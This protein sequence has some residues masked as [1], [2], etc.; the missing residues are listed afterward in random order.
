MKILYQF[1][2]SPFG[3]N[4]PYK[5]LSDPPS[6]P[7]SIRPKSG[8]IRKT[9]VFVTPPPLPPFPNLP[10]QTPNLLARL[11]LVS[12]KRCPMAH[13]LPVRMCLISSSIL[14]VKPWGISLI[15]WNERTFIIINSFQYDS[16]GRL[17]IYWQRALKNNEFY[18]RT[19]DFILV[20]FPEMQLS[21]S[22]LNSVKSVIFL[23]S[24]LFLHMQCEIHLNAYINLKISKYNKFEGF[25]KTIPT[26][27]F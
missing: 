18:P 21:W 12:N 16:L 5:W 10:K 23:I 15:F 8:F 4:D 13:V 27:L 9:E 24:L 22:L 26:W 3:L 19:L 17:Y 25:L 11:H 6:P 2:I 1:F 14:S 20:R 7:P